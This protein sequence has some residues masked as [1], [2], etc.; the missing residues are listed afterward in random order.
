MTNDTQLT[1]QI[2]STAKQ[3]G[4]GSGFKIVN[5]LTPEERA[6]VFGGIRIFFRVER[7]SAKGP[8]GTFWRVTKLCG[9]AVCPRVPTFAEVA[10]LRSE[11]GI[12]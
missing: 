11:T 12:V 3:S 6:S 4:Y 1:F 10:F 5:F 8:S 7:V 2:S 9:R